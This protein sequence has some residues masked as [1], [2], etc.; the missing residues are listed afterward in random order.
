MADTTREHAEAIARATDRL[1][2]MV[3]RIEG[4][5]EKYPPPARIPLEESLT[6]S[7]ELILDLCRRV[8]AL[9]RTAR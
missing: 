1:E 8:I 4:L 3:Q 5:L 6:L 2:I 9:E 7:H